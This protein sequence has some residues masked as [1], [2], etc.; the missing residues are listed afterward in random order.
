MISCYARKTGLAGHQVRAYYRR[1]EGGFYRLRGRTKSAQKASSLKKSSKANSS[2]DT[3]ESSQLAETTASESSAQTDKSLQRKPFVT[4]AMPTEQEMPMLITKMHNVLA[5]IDRC[6]MLLRKPFR[7]GTPKDVR[8][9]WTEAMDNFCLLANL[10]CRFLRQDYGTAPTYRHLSQLFK[11]IGLDLDSSPLQ[12]R[13]KKFTD[14]C[15][16]LVAQLESLWI[17]HS[18]EICK[19]VSLC[20]EDDCVGVTVSDFLDVLKAFCR[21]ILSNGMD[22]MSHNSI[23]TEPSHTT[24][25]QSQITDNALDAN[26]LTDSTTIEEPSVW[27][28]EQDPQVNSLH[29]AFAQCH[30]VLKSRMSNSEVS[31]SLET[32]YSFR[33]SLTLLRTLDSSYPVTEG[34][35]RRNNYDL[36]NA[37]NSLEPVHISDDQKSD[38]F[39]QNHLTQALNH[40]KS[41]LFD[42]IE[43]TST[44]KILSLQT[45]YSKDILDAAFAQLLKQGIIRKNTRYDAS[46][47]TNPL[48]LFDYVTSKRTLQFIK[49]LQSQPKGIDL[50]SSTTCTSMPFSSVSITFPSMPISTAS[51]TMPLSTSPTA[52]STP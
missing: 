26:A 44:S 5:W 42:P 46:S 45:Q 6:S 20:R 9:H 25:L 34:G 27:P 52:F 18:Q 28:F 10:T 22:G 40:I 41:L 39:P 30:G 16:N 7:M 23:L 1:I 37:V 48:A 32:N 11:A 21:V 17:A 50:K 51:N 14:K 19:D 35:Y 29:D 43:G 24:A 33:Y 38:D 49:T 12:R 47:R 13:C 15:V 4:M 31:S 8:G 36:S 3:E 2:D